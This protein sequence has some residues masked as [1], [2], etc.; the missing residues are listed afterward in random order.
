MRRWNGWGDDQ[1][2]MALPDSAEQF[3]TTL[4]GPGK[5]L[6]DATLEQVIAS[7]PASRL[8]PHPLISTDAETRIRHARGQSLP[9]WLAMRE[10]QFEI[11]PDGVAFPEN[12]QHIQDLLQWADAED[13]YIIPYGGGTSVAG[14]INPIASEKP[15]VT[16][17]MSRMTQLIHLDE[18]S[19]IATFGAGA[20]GPAV[21]SQLRA[22]G[23]TLGHFPQSFEYSTLGGWIASRSSGQQSLRY[24]R[25]E[26]LFAGGQVETLNGSM[27]IPTF[28]ASSAGPDIREMLLGSEGRF[29]IISHADV[30]VTPLPETEDFYVA[31]FPDWQR[32]AD[33]CRDIAHQRIPLS[34]LRVSNA[35]ETVTQLKLAG[36]ESAIAWLEKY[37]S[38]RGANSEKCMLTYGITGSTLQTR[39]TRQQLKPLLKQYGGVSTGTL[40]GK[41]WQQNRFRLPYL[42]EAL[43]KLGYVVDTLETSTNWSNVTSLHDKIESSL[44]HRLTDEGEKVHVFTH[45]SH[46]YPQ[47][48]SLYTSYVYRCANTYQQTLEYWKKLKQ[49]ASETIVNNGGTISHQHGVGKDHKP[50]LPVEKGDKGIGAIKSL[51]NYFDPKGKLNPDTLV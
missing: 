47:G 19:L 2:H 7:V 24:G 25:I 4:I 34:M 1:Q 31:F 37:L 12:Q 50:W 46:V 51:C 36:H 18:Q 45:L 23:Y 5:P 44:R 16:I 39:Q 35:T 22:K 8:A 6:A 32:A 29:G 10:G 14:H 43:W 42:R 30:R 33:F 9:D 48:C 13:V 28:P 11:F 3:L 26:Q 17:A 49:T 15:V 41:R 21:E 40:L 38:F 27:T 20:P